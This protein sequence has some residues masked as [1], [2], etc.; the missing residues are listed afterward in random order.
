MEIG[1]EIVLKATKVDGV[2]DAD[3]LK[4]TAAV[5]FDR[6]SYHDVLQRNL[7]V[8]DATAITLCM[9]HQLPV[10]VFNIGVRGKMRKILLGEQEGT[11]I[12]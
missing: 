6:I 12:N 5:K 2:Y 8:M 3:P 7:Q 4:N 10:A 1:A 11:L 9:E